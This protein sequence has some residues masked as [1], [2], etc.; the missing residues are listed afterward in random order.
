MIVKPGLS[1][2]CLNCKV[3]SKLH[4]CTNMLLQPL[5]HMLRML[6]ATVSAGGH[7]IPLDMVQYHAAVNQPS[8]PI[9]EQFTV[10]FNQY[11]LSQTC[12]S[13]HHQ[14][15]MTSSHPC[16]TPLLKLQTSIAFIMKPTTCTAQITCQHVKHVG[17]YVAGCPW[18][19]LCISCTVPCVGGPVVWYSCHTHV[20]M[21]ICLSRASLVGCGLRQG[22][23]SRSSSLVL[24]QLRS[25]VELPLLTLYWRLWPSAGATKQ[26][27][28]VSHLNWCPQT[29]RLQ[30]LCQQKKAGQ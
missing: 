3:F 8:L 1:T 18:P 20:L 10:H 5:H 9:C 25:S 7:H 24:W 22:L 19:I 23:S 13:A 2:H 6:S 27:W 30:S 26:E 11:V 28:Y 15:Q 17:L 29:V 4:M 21:S 12:R 14:C 16:L